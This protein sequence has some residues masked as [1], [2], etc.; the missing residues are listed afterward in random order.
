MDT[1]IWR[2]GSLEDLSIIADIEKQ[3]FSDPW[4]QDDFVYCVENDAIVFG[5]M[6]DSMNEPVAYAVIYCAADEGELATIAVEKSHRGQ[7]LGCRVLECACEAARQ[8]QV[9]R[10]YLEVRVSNE[11]A[12][13]LYKSFGFEDEGIRKNFYDFP[14]EDAYVMKKVI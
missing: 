9:T 5:V 10:V 14:R 7:G 8:L 13:G 11:P 6:A 4:K 3:S 12:I 1:Y 2:P